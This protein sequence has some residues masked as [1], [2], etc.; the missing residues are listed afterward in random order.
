MQLNDNGKLDENSAM[1]HLDKLKEDDEE[2]YNTIHDIFQKCYNEVTDED[3]P[4]DT[5]AKLSGCLKK[6][7]TAVIKSWFVS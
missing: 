3:D 2:M 7:A 5:A 6:L 1:A 4:C